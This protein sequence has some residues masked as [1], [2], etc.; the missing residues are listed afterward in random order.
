VKEYAM[1]RAHVLRASTIIGSKVTNAEHEDL[2]KIEE[3]MLNTDDD[4]IAYAVLSFG[5]FLGMDDKFFA[6]PWK[7]LE[8]D[9]EE[10]C[11]I[12]DVPREKLQNAPGFPKNNWPDANV[13]TFGVDIYEYYGA[14]RGPRRSG[15]DP[16]P[17]YTDRLPPYS[18]GELDDVS[19]DD[20]PSPSGPILPSGHIPPAGA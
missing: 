10:D 14:A 19:L 16:L 20:V 17:P 18:Q 7:A 6:V 4:G 11:F 3:L 2:G 1:K 5:G 15:P 12:L 9:H 8:L 13:E